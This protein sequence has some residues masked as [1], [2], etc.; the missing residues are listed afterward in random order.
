MTPEEKK[1]RSKKH[2]QINK[3]LT[4]IEEYRARLAAAKMADKKKAR[5]K[6]EKESN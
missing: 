5:A 1:I 2:Q 4:K 6:S 3:E